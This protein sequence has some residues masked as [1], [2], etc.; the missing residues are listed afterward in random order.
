MITAIDH[1]DVKTPSLAD[2][3]GFL[4]VLGFRPLREGS[5]SV[6]LSLPGENQV[7]IEVR[8]DPALDTVVA[9]HVALRL[10]GGVEALEDLKARGIS[11]D[12]ERATIARTGRIVSNLRDSHGGKWQL[13]E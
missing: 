3:V 8:E 2:T 1:I 12:R 10:E 6:E 13:A 7:T 5:D 4:S 9:D 11:F